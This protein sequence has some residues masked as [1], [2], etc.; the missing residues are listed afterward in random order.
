MDTG[1]LLMAYIPA[2][3]A[4]A[5]FAMLIWK[6]SSNTNAVLTH[7]AKEM[8][9]EKQLRL[10]A[11]KKYER[12]MARKDQM[13]MDTQAQ[14]LVAASK[15]TMG[16]TTGTMSRSDEVEA[17]IE[18]QKDADELAEE[19]IAAHDMSSAEYPDGG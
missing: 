1:V 15:Y 9:E 8:S 18:R 11:D 14:L 7:Y 5:V 2:L 4:A 6:N 16:G 19:F 10:L 13:L 12:E 3:L 17:G